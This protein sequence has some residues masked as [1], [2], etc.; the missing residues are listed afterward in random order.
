MKVL[1]QSSWYWLPPVKECSLIPVGESGCRSSPCSGTE[2]TSSDYDAPQR[3]R[4][5]PALVYLVRT[6]V[7]AGRSLAR[8]QASRPLFP[9]L[10]QQAQGLSCLPSRPPSSEPSFCS[11]LL[12][13]PQAAAS[14]PFVPSP[15][16]TDSRQVRGDS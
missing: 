13:L 5:Q 14:K 10:S 15:S 1:E 3:V 2:L 11:N 9:S 8:A 6:N 16:P 7:S 4:L 12:F